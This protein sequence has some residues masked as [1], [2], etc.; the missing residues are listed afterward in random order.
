RQGA[1]PQVP[2]RRRGRHPDPPGPAADDER[3]GHHHPEPL[4]P[5]RPRLIV[6]TPTAPKTDL[7]MADAVALPDPDPPAASADVVL[8]ARGLSVWYGPSL[9]LRAITIAIPRNQI[10]ALIGP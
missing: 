5:I 2:G 4:R 9:A 1:R 7:P 10:T 3:R 8:E 6:M